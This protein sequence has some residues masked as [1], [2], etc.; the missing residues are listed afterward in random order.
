MPRRKP[1]KRT[2]PVPGLTWR[3]STAYW[4]RSH[5]RLP[6]GRVVRSLSTDR[7][8]LAVQYAAALN[9]LMDRGDWGVIERWVSGQVHISDLA[10]AVREGEYAKL[11]RLN[12]EGVRLGPTIDLFLRRAT[13]TLAAQRVANMESLFGQLREFLGDDFPMH[14]M[15][16]ERAEAFLHSPKA[17]NAGQVWAIGTQRE[18]RTVCKALW[19]YAQE[20][21]EEAAAQAGATATLERNPWSKAKVSAWRRTR[22]AWCSPAEA[23]D[24]VQHPATV[25]LPRRAFMAI[26]F[27]AG[28]RDGEIRHLRPGLD[29]DL[30]AATLTV[31]EHDA[32]VK[33]RP[34]TIHSI[35]TVPIPPELVEIIREHMALGFAGER[36]LFR[37]PGRDNPLAGNTVRKWAREAYE[38]AG[39]KY[40]R[41]EGDGLTIHSMR[42]SYA[43][44]LLSQKTP[45]N[46][47][48]ARLGN[49]PV[50]VFKTY[51]HVMPSDEQQATD[52]ISR[53]S[54]GEL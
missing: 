35:R 16:R 51:G 2:A 43:T 39:L 5:D 26:G 20:N 36:Y 14:A 41:N 27:Y 49:S 31:Q 42:H 11:N 48:A 9:T 46:T 10:R 21:E 33:W 32:P 24:V 29:V 4:Q 1:K 18:A 15:T 54:R 12:M 17:S 25:G 13:A 45:V 47:V 28:L 38:A 6:S 23:R 40:G 30:D 22:F 50:E 3:G 8:D 19:Y 52:I 53:A 44:W 37:A 34:K 7:A